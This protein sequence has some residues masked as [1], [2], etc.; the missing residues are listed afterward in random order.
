[1]HW[2]NT[3]N[4]SWDY[5]NNGKNVIESFDVMDGENIFYG[6]N[7]KGNIKNLLDVNFFWSNL[8]DCYNSVIIWNNSSHIFFS[9]DCF[10]NV[11]NLF[12]CI[13][14]IEWVKNCFACVWLKQKEYCILNKQYT[15]EEYN[16]LVPKIIEYMQKTWEWGEFFPPILS[17]FAYN[18]SEAQ[19]FFPIIPKEGKNW[20]DFQYVDNEW[21]TYK[22]LED[23]WNKTIFKW[24]T[25]EA[26]FP[27]VE[28][29]I[30]SDKL[31]QDIK[32]IPDDILNWAIKCE[33][34][35]KPFRI[36]KQELNFYRKHNLP[37]PKKHPDQRHIERLKL[38]NPRNIYTR[39]CDKCG[40]EIQTTYAPER[41]EI[42]YCEE[43]YNKE[44]I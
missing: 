19:N 21:N 5:I 25:I 29:I 13:C 26:P 16:A 4:I 9:S 22:S 18:N 37:I 41:Q 43:C 28:K 6:T 17:S 23:A 32:D 24:S 10:E 44:I 38:R 3:E 1:M 20:K 40:K 8:S 11:N 42:V 7:L 30:P 2:K 39:N 12:Y 33:I 15:K 34:T 36:T 31:R 35:Q 14:C 27:K